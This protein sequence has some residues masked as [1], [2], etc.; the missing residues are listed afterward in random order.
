MFD[1]FP[2][3]EDEEERKIK[4]AEQKES[5]GFVDPSLDDARPKQHGQRDPIHIKAI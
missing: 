2:V 5:Q 3:W 4:V 1:E